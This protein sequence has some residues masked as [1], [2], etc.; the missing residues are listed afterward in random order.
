MDLSLI[1]RA[2]C[3]GVHRNIISAGCG[4]VLVVSALGGD[5]VHTLRLILNNFLVVGT[6][7]FHLDINLYHSTTMSMVRFISIPNLL[8]THF[9]TN[10]FFIKSFLIVL[11]SKHHNVFSYRR[12]FFSDV[13]MK[14]NTGSLMEEDK[15]NV[16]LAK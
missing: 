13:E 3:T 15:S 4:G 16:G 12:C 6:Q 5:E 2:Y 11:I 1:L 8:H 7:L 10:K 14:L 9:S